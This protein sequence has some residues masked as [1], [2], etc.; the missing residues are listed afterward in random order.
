MSRDPIVVFG[1]TGH[2]GSRIVGKLLD[3][4]EIVRVLSR[5]ALKAKAILGDGAEVI[6]GDVT[7]RDTV[8]ESL[9]G[10]RAILIALSAM[11]IKSIKRMKEIERDAVLM[12]MDEAGKAHIDRL[13]YLSGYEIREAIL[14]KLNIKLG[15][16]KLEIEKEIRESGFNWTILGCGPSFELFFALLRNNRLAV[17][18]GGMNRVPVISPEDVGEIAAQAVLRDDLSGKRFRLTGPES[19]SFPEAAERMSAITN[20]QIKHIKLPLVAV[21]VV[22]LIVS[23]FT[24]FVSFIYGSLKLLNNFPSDLAMNVPEDHRVLLETFAYVPVTFDDE[25]KKRFAEMR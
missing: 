4:N 18:G 6:E 15:E 2:Y 10:A 19:I 23:P 22:S 17:P 24:P 13:V 8:V 25:I 20:K 12:I 21:K 5:D 9:Q 11:N 7:D 1:G 3:K 14:K 16:I